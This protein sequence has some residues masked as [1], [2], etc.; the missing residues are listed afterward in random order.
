MFFCVLCLYQKSTKRRAIED[1]ASGE[2]ALREYY[3]IQKHEYSAYSATGIA[4]MTEDESEVM[5]KTEHASQYG[6]FTSRAFVRPPWVGVLS[7]CFTYPMAE[8]LSPTTSW[9]LVETPLP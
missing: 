4:D 7:S 8:V 5:D 3:R 6:G 2:R 1:Q 9:K